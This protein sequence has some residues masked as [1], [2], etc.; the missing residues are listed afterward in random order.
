MNHH[1]VASTEKTRKIS[2]LFNT[3]S[4]DKDLVLQ[5]LLD[6]NFNIWNIIPDDEACSKC[7]KYLNRG[8]R[9]SYSCPGCLNMSRLCDDFDKPFIIELNPLTQ[10]RRTFVASLK[11]TFSDDDRKSYR[12]PKVGKKLIIEKYPK[13]KIIKEYYSED[14]SSS[15]EQSWASHL[16]LSK[17]KT[18]CLDS[19]T[20]NIIASWILEDNVA[21]RQIYHAYACNDTINTITEDI[22]VLKDLP[23]CK[24]REKENVEDI[25]LKAV[26]EIVGLIYQGL[27]F[28]QNVKKYEFLLTDIP[29]LGF[30]DEPYVSTNGKSYALTLKF[31][32]LKHSQ[33]TYNLRIIPCYYLGPNDEISDLMM[34]EEQ[35]SIVEKVPEH[36]LFPEET[37][38][39]KIFPPEGGMEVLS[40]DKIF[41][42]RNLGYYLYDELNI[43]YFLMAF[44]GTNLNCQSLIVSEPIL[45][46][47]YA[48]AFPNNIYTLEN[49]NIN[50]NL[51]SQMIEYINKLYIS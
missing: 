47:L 26:D 4:Q 21:I 22:K 7:S 19:V 42:L 25:Y 16:S 18:L 30:I 32:N 37:M 48:L 3:W 24:M 40:Y 12:Y 20:L 43:Y 28:F 9:K 14:I 31:Q 50:G 41:A 11:Q 15:W 1:H 29:A 33:I 27:I 6:D 23:Y 17:N 36:Y 8:Y 45:Q 2:H 51:A 39:G 46:K 34:D 49:F 38:E 44:L 5:S 10:N 35:S 13:G